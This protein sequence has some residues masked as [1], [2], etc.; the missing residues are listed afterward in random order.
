MAELLGRIGPDPD[1]LRYSKSLLVP[2]T[3]E[4]LDAAKR[5][6]GGYSETGGY[7]IFRVKELLLAVFH[8]EKCAAVAALGRLGPDAVPELIRVARD[9][10][11]DGVIRRLA[12]EETA[13]HGTPATVGPLLMEALGYTDW[14]LPCGAAEVIASIGYKAALP[15]LKRLAEDERAEQN[16]A[17]AVK[18]Y[19]RLT[20]RSDAH[21]FL[22]KSLASKSAPVRGD[23]VYLLGEFGERTD[24]P[25]VIELLS[26]NDWYVRGQADQA[27]R[28]LADK[29]E[30]VGYD[31]ARMNSTELWRA[32]WR[33]RK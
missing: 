24:I 31:A 3:T 20:D 1:S 23:A 26:D 22:L 13:R 17:A 30:G 27:L 25:R 10:R 33:N 19:V 7:I 29:P 18:A 6:V 14:Q 12:I 5:T 32:W 15:V 8:G 16:P 21:Q 11:F 4:W 2:H 9:D 28:G